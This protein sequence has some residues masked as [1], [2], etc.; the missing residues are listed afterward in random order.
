MTEI[1]RP[2]KSLRRV[3]ITGLGVV[4]PV[5]IGREAFWQGLLSPQPEGERR[6]HDFDPT[7]C[8]DDPKAIRRADRFEQMAVCAAA[9]ALAQAGPL[10]ADPDRIGVLVGTGVGGAQSHEDQ[11]IVNE[12]KGPRRVSP[13]VVPMMM[14][15]AAAAAISIGHGLQGP[16]ESL[17][18]ACATGTHA[19]G[20]AARWIQWGICDAAVAGG[21]EAAM[22]PVA[23]AGFANMR[24]LSPSGR[25]RPFDAD[26]D[27]FVISEGAAVVVLEEL[28]RARA[29]GA[30][31]LAEVLGSAS[32]A[33]AHHI[34]APAPGGAGALRCMRRALEDAGLEPG[35]IVHVNAHGTST[36]LNDLAEAQGISQLFG[37]PG[38][39][40]TS[41]KGVTGHSLGAAGA[42]EA[43]ALVLSL[44]HGLIP[45]TDGLEQFDPAL[46]PID[47]VQKEARRFTPGPSL[48]NSFGFGGHNG[49]L[50]L[51]P[52]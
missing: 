15:N 1:D 25:S 19:I 6:V 27:G 37:S 49:T 41:I 48:S 32:L 29:R 34:T 10:D 35:Q 5:G 4:S 46:P 28:E 22:T 45:P 36:E 52:V 12:Q 39:I 43:V 24:A 3:A 23:L 7:R 18:T 44:Q 38:P 50:V 42:I 17:A 51:G 31:I 11:T 14:S 9:E 33:D 16:C 13:F 47:V 20:Q 26:R 21:A 8:Y 40:V 30:S 2:A